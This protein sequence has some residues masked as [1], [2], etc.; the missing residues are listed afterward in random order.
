MHK[1][2]KIM[3]LRNIFYPVFA[4][5]FSLCLFSC[6]DD[7][8]DNSGNNN[9]NDDNTELKNDYTATANVKTATLIRGTNYGDNIKGE[10]NIVIYEDFN[11]RYSLL[12]T[13]GN[14]CL[15]AEYR[16]DGSFSTQSASSAKSGIHDIGQ[17]YNLQDVTE[18]EKINDEY[19][20]Y[21]LYR[22]GYFYSTVQPTHGY[23]AYFTT[24]NEEL[25]FVR[26]YIKDYTLNTSSTLTSITIQ[27]QLY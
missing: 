10:D 4:V 19:H 24:E 7:D 16:E 5:I 2:Q 21:G 1:N 27:Y 18:K 26:I 17:V 6:S 22:G 9:N 20:S 25:K 12:L 13:S 15:I 14:I 23:S 3:K 11:S 8:D